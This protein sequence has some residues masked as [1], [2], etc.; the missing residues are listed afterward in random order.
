M[1]KLSIHWLIVFLSWTEYWRLYSN[2]GLVPCSLL[3]SGTSSLSRLPPLGCSALQILAALPNS[4]SIS[5]S[6][7]W[8]KNKFCWGFS[9]QS[10]CWKPLPGKVPASYQSCATRKAWLPTFCAVFWLPKVTGQ[11]QYLLL[12]PPAEKAK[13]N[14]QRTLPPASSFS[15]TAK[16]E[17]GT[18]PRSPNGVAE[19]QLLKPVPQPPRVYQEIESGARAGSWTSTLCCEIQAL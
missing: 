11:T 19:A 4:K 5:D 15:V 8:W 13:P 12:Y 14:R 2:C 7:F 17:Q 10:C 18:K 1:F 3:F 6:F 16:S 9:S